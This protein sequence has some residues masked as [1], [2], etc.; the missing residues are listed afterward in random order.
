MSV[1]TVDLSDIIAK[2]TI[3][4]REAKEKLFRALHR[5]NEFD[6]LTPNEMDMLRAL[7]A[8]PSVKFSCRDIL[9]KP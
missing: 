9:N 3:E 2:Q 1:R 7:Q 5:Y 4:V 6:Y 8:S